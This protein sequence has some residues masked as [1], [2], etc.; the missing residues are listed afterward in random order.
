[1]GIGAAFA[2]GLVKGFTQNIQQEKA[3][4]LAEQQK[5]DA[6]EQT[7]L[8]SVLTGKATK[9][10]YASVSKLIKSAQQQI[11]E[12]PDI[13]IFGRATD[14]IDIDFASLQSTLE[15]AGDYNFEIK[16]SKH[17]LGFSMAKDLK[18][19]NGIL[20]EAS[21]LLQDPDVQKKL[22][23]DELLYSKLEPI[24]TGAQFDIYS[25]ERSA[26]M[27]GNKEGNFVR[28]DIYAIYPGLSNYADIGKSSHGI[29]VPEYAQIVNSAGLEKA[30][31]GFEIV[32]S[33]VIK[34]PTTGSLSF[35]NV[36]LA[37]ES[38]PA[39]SNITKRVSDSLGMKFQEGQFYNYWV[40]IDGNGNQLSMDKQFFAVPG[41]SV[42]E[43]EQ[44]LNASVQ[45]HAQNFFPVDGLDPD[46]G[47]L[48]R[49]TDDNV[50]VVDDFIRTTDA[51]NFQ[52]LT[53]AIAPSMR[54]DKLKSSASVSFYVQEDGGE[55]RQNYV[56]QKQYGTDLAGKQEKF[57]MG[58][59]IQQRDAKQTAL[60][61]LNNLKA[62][63]AE[64]GDPE[65]YVSFKRIIG[66]W[67]G[68]QGI[69]AAIASDVF[70]AG[71]E[72][73]SALESDKL[74][75]SV[76]DRMVAAKGDAV[77]D[78]GTSLA[79]LEAMRISLAFQLARAA[80][81]SGRLSNQDIQ[82]QLD[83]LGAGFYTR[84]QA[85]AKIQV[86]IDEM[87]RDVQK[88]NVLVNYGRGNAQISQMDAKIIDA[89]IAADSLMNRAGAIRGK[90]NQ[91]Q[92]ASGVGDDMIFQDINMS[93]RK[94]PNGED[95]Y[96]SLAPDGNY[97]YDSNS[98]QLF[99]YKDDQG[100]TKTISA[101]Q[102]PRPSAAGTS[103]QSSPAASDASA[104]QSSPAAPD[105]SA[106]GSPEGLGETLAP[107]TESSTMNITD[108]MENGQPRYTFSGTNSGGRVKNN[109]TGKY[110]EGRF[111]IDQSGNLVRLDSKINA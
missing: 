77:G 61:Q 59:M 88:M 101:N 19:T 52:Q 63:R 33:K 9:S 1:M 18:D 37:Q 97:R 89:A 16:G 64:V 103:S 106:A 2:T 91:E 80:D 38:L 99:M 100:N 73:E 53:M 30:P 49:M 102:L 40:G 66:V 55:S 83:R 14:A 39:F 56:L 6:F 20:T 45:I 110:E 27:Q 5:I 25:K 3:R 76:Y 98:N 65:P 34:D 68:D 43:K 4:R 87:E 8:Q 10:G 22:K 62:K 104:P 75:L 12:R 86:V 95:L 13:D 29:N 57:T 31:E 11:D 67:T 21:T 70:G 96:F 46:S 74:D 72:K 41:V 81:P 107:S 93:T 94:G 36:V 7:A 17:T 79:E 15:S 82:Q 42:Q 28:P 44:A 51:K 108:K 24:I 105:A 47:S 85:L 32:G 58:Y 90:R 111:I 92:I 50:L 69:G 60:D 23:E 35:G 109:E 48:Y 84:D 78:D 71:F 54:Y 26:W